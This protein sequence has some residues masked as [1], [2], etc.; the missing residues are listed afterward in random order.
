MSRSQAVV[1]AL[2]MLIVAAGAASRAVNIN[3]S[4]WL[5]EAAVANG[6]IQDTLL[7]TLLYREWQ[8]PS[9]PLFA[10][11]VRSAAGFFGLSNFSLRLVPVLSSILALILWVF[12]SR[13]LLP[14]PL[15]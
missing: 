2:L 3:Q 1:A 14:H 8:P 12:I 5:D 4:L 10:L 9:P 7:Q 6:F 11:L 15:R 13:R